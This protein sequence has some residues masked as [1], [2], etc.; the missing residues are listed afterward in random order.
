MGITLS[1]KA[2]NPNQDSTQSVYREKTIEHLFESHLLVHDWNSGEVSLDIYK[3]EIDR[4]GF[5]I[6]LSKNGI[7]RYVQL[8]TSTVDSKAARQKVHINLLKMVNGCIV[9]IVV[10]K[11]LRIQYYLTVI[12]EVGSNIGTSGFET[13]KHTKGNALGVKSERPNIRVIPKSKF[14]IAR[15]RDELVHRLFPPAQRDC[16][17]NR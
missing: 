16:L 15:S 4:N 8:K 13:A 11:E 2:Y 1:T 3:P 12:P 14:V 10:D 5:D 6:V 9:W 17:T 7:T